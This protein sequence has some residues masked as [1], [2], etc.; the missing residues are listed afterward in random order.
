MAL[1]II[2]TVAVFLFGI[3]VSSAIVFIAA[4][5]RTDL[6]QGGDFTMAHLDVI[7]KINE[8]IEKAAAWR[9]RGVSEEQLSALASDFV[10]LHRLRVFSQEAIECDVDKRDEALLTGVIVRG[11]DYP[12]TLTRIMQRMNDRSNA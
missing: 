5:P 6:E 9:K 2:G 11:W 1:E 10:K 8:M 12:K 7:N 4:T 3:F